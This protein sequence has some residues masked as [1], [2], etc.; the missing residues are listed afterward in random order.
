MATKHIAVVGGMN[1]DIGGR[2]E[3]RL[4]ARDSNP[5]AVTMRPGGVGHNIA[6]DLRLLGLEV[7]LLTAVGDDFFGSALLESCRAAGI[8]TRLSLLCPGM[9]SSTYLYVNGE[10]G[11]M[12]LAIADMEVTA[13]ITPEALAPHLGALNGADAVVLDANLS[14]E[15]LEYLA[16]HVS[17]P[18]YADAVST[19]KAPRLLPLL[20]RLAALKPNAI[21]AEILT[22]EHDAEQAA[23]ALL[24]RGVERVFVSIGAGGLIA[25]EGER[26]LRLPCIPARSV[27]TTGAGDAATAAVVWSGV[28]GLTL[29]QTALAART[30][31]AWATES[32]EPDSPR[33]RELPALFGL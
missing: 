4:V 9:R 12:Q 28:C 10:D 2:P 33:L 16:Q 30:A 7:S 22:G 18:L 29:K 15:T 1:M 5:G 17:V 26:L 11:D 24:R 31:G 27:N 32:E 3:G 8:D 19:A 23:R 21:E 14:T 25:A 20:D 13:R 6:C